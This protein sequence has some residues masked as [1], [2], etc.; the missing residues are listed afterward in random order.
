MTETPL[1]IPQGMK[2]IQIPTM[3]GVIELNGRLLGVVDNERRGRPRWAEIELYDYIDTDRSHV[4][5]EPSVDDHEV[6]A[7]YGQRL[8]LLHTMGHSVV[9]HRHD[10]DCNKGVAIPVED[11][12]E[13]AEFPRDLEACEDCRPLDWQKMPEGTIYDLEVLR[14]LIYK[15]RTPEAV[16]ERLRRP[17]KVTCDRCNGSGSYPPFTRQVCDECRGRGWV[18]GPPALSAPGSRL[19][20]M[21]KFKD[22]AIRQAAQRTVRL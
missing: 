15:C 13:R 9:Y 4:A 1:T 11:F 2:L 6:I 7:T 3:D 21:V 18:S 17:S 16:L 20:E 22:P 19:I 8:Y 5:P 14:H 10:G 12:P